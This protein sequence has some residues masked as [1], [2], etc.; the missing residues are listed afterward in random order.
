[1]YITRLA[2]PTS[3]DKR[4]QDANLIPYSVLN[5]NIIGNMLPSFCLSSDL[6]SLDVISLKLL[7]ASTPL[8]TIIGVIVILKFQV[9]LKCRISCIFG[10]KRRFSFVHAFTAFI[11]LSYSRFCDVVSTLLNPGRVWS[12]DGT[13]VVNVYQYGEYNYNGKEFLRYKVIGCII[14]AILCVIPLLLLQYPLQWLERIC[15][16]RWY[17]SVMIGTILDMFQGCYKDDRRYFAG[18]YPILRLLLNFAPLLTWKSTQYAMEQ[19]TLVVF[20]ML[21][22]ILQPYRNSFYNYID[23]MILTN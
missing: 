5:L 11:V 15:P 2:Q 17:P 18:F 1:M 12:S 21:V 9:C 16:T 19:T 4:V 3:I 8:I 6:N 20:I 10:L 23:I 13:N 7:E 14:T 22:S